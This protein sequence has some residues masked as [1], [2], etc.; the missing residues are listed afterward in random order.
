MKVVLWLL[1]IAIL[2]YKKTTSLPKLY[3]SISIKAKTCLSGRLL[4]AA[5]TGEADIG[6]IS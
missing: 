5:S 1:Y 6:K 4:V 2:W 3:F